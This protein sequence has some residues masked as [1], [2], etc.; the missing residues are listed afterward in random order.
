MAKYPVLYDRNMERKGIV[1]A[2]SLSASLTARPMS[3]ANMVV[4]DSV[5]VQMRDFVQ[6]FFPDGTWQFFRV[7]TIAN[8]IGGLL[9]VQME[10]GIVWAEDYILPEKQDDLTDTPANVLARFF[11]RLTDTKWRLGTVEPTE[12]IDVQYD[13]PNVMQG[14]MDVLGHCKGYT[15]QFDQSGDLWYVNMVALSSVVGCEGRISRNLLTAPVINY[16]DQEQCTRVYIPGKSWHIDADNIAEVGVI[17]RTINVDTVGVDDDELKEQCRQYLEE[18]KKPAVSITVDAQELASMTGEPFDRFVEGT[19]CRLCLMDYGGVVIQERISTRIY[20]DLLGAP[21][22]VQVQIA[23]QLPDV[24]SQINDITVAQHKIKTSLNDVYSGVVE[25]DGRLTSVYN[26]VGLRLDAQAAEIELKASSVHVNAV[27]QRVNDVSLEID[28]LNA[29]IA[30]KAYSDDVADDLEA[31]SSEM[32]VAADG[33]RAQIQAGDKVV[34]ELAVTVEGLENWTTD[35][36][37]NISELTNTVRGMESKVTTVDG[38]VATLTNTA[39]GLTSTIQQQGMTLSELKTRSDE[40]SAN[41]QDVEGN[42]GA[43]T[44]TSNSVAAK[45]QN[46][47]NKVATLV[48]TADGLTNNIADQNQVLASFTTRIDEIAAMVTNGN[49]QTA[50]L[51]VTANSITQKVEDV[52]TSMS[53]FQVDLEGIHGEVVDVEK[54]ANARMDILAGRIDLKASQ[55]TVNGME[56][57]LRQAEI[58]INGA[59]ASIKLKASQETVNGMETRLRQAEIDINGAESTIGLKADKTYV[60]NLF[61]KTITTENLSAKI[62]VLNHI[63]NESV[64]GMTA[65]FQTV[66]AQGVRISGAHGLTLAGTDAGWKELEVVTGAGLSVSKANTPPFYGRENEL[67]SNGVSYVS[68]VTLNVTRGTIHYLGY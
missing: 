37:G 67:L 48:L 38:K 39:D 62:S 57:R 42:I 7:K 46:T 2:E 13:H 60:D 66:I 28:G 33:I 9:T 45:V 4:P 54:N 52:G 32:T 59:E 44:V 19:I 43:L 63:S 53:Q 25:V 65:D 6:I 18:H 47:E 51:I 40:I 64:Q 68:N 20:P 34:S 31:L 22:Y 26:E 3:V 24:S 8:E 56:T 29:E 16:N 30:L 5:D 23:S 61:A 11:A 58:D 15:Y 36:A 41:V 49:G 50:Q 12:R 14:I 55:E 10:H 35:S 21:E 17:E 1:Y 27:D